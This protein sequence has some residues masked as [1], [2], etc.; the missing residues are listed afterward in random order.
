MRGFTGLMLVAML[1]QCAPRVLA[2]DRGLSK[3]AD[4]SGFVIRLE[5][6][7]KKHSW[8][9]LLSAA[10]PTLYYLT[11]EEGDDSF[12]FKGQARAPFLREFLTRGRIDRRAG[13]GSWRL[14]GRWKGENSYWRP[15]FFERWNP[16]IVRF[17]KAE[18]GR[19]GELDYELQVRLGYVS[20]LLVRIG[21]FWRIRGFDRNTA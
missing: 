17:K 15:S 19:P 1:C 2:S 8:R 18:R 5:R 16:Q 9:T 20:I 13:G 14:A 3:T 11:S 10:A 6:A 7:W 21:K 12:T 4:P